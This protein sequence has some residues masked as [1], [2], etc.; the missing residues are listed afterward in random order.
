M[1]QCP[2]FI[3]QPLVWWVIGKYKEIIKFKCDSTRIEGFK[4]CR[5]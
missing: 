3:N 1:G 4:G 5:A 2:K